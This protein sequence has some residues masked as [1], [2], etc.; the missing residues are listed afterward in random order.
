MELRKVT[1]DPRPCHSPR[2]A[3]DLVKSLS[4]VHLSVTP[5]TIQSVEFSRVRVRVRVRVR[6]LGWVACPFSRGSF[7]PR[8]GTK[9]SHTAGGLSTS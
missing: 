9:V 4:H 5:W 8:D 6:I 3:R 1:G 2:L 7:Q